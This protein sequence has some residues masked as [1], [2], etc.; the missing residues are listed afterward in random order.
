[1]SSDGMEKEA[2]DA[3]RERIRE[4]KKD[5]YLRN[6]EKMKAS[7]IAYYAAH[8]E[9]RKEWQRRYR[10]DHSDEIRAKD[11]ARRAKTRDAWKPGEPIGRGKE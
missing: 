9:E 2:L 7:S 11:K 4:Y 1:M 8:R 6:R 10:K 5:Y 3:V